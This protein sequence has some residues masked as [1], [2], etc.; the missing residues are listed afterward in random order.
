MGSALFSGV[1]GL[2]AHQAMLDVAGNNV[3]N[4]NTTGFKSSRVSFSELLSQTI[5]TASAP[6]DDAGGT[7]PV[8]SGNGV[9]VASVDKLM[10]QGSLLNT[11]QP[12]DMAIEG[13][14][15]F[16]LRGNGKTVFTRVGSFAVD[17]AFYLVDPSTGYRVQRIGDE[18]LA[19]GFQS[20]S[21]NNIRVPYDVAL[22]AKATKT[23]TFTGNL[24]AD[25]SD[26]SALVLA[27]G[28][29]NLYT[30]SGAAAGTTTTLANLDQTTNISGDTMTIS[31]T[32]HAG[33]AIGPRVVTLT[34][35]MT[36][37]DLL[38]EI[39]LAY[40]AIP[41]GT[42][43]VT[44]SISNGEVFVTAKSAG[45]SLMDMAMTYNSG[46]GGTFDVPS[47]WKIDTPGAEARKDVNAEIYDTLGISHTVTGSF[48]KT[49]DDNKWDFV[50]TSIS[51]DIESIGD[52]RVQGVAFL[53]DGSYGG[54]D[55][56]DPNSGFLDVTFGNTGTNTTLEL[57]L[58]TVG[59]TDGITQFGNASTGA[60]SN[61]DGYASGNLA[62][63]SISRDGIISGLFSNGVRRD[64]AAL[65]IATFQNPSGLE[66]IGNNYYQSTGNSGDPVPTKA[67]EGGAGAVRGGA[68]EKSNVDVASEFVTL[69]QAQNGFQANARTIRVANDMLQELTNLIR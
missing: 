68:L 54:L 12:L 67:L 13:E 52:R 21:N 32:D 48:V 61:Q 3:A 20:A 49:T 63:L 50:M 7:N 22:P 24:K 27:A 40:S 51:G 56:T 38:Q 53:N 5:R 15:F 14:G 18:G 45:Y 59:K 69:I 42:S 17:S 46:G 64:I 2:T 30:A 25:D 41:G 31:G 34:S 23:V 1:S 57:N 66:A 55:G 19:E 33:A 10:G 26:P 60:I 8:Q 4:V 39:E 47:F 35:S 36:V 6:T 65:R 16:M 29:G 9:N 28:E 58:G 37:G 44:A 11:G 62:S 43:S